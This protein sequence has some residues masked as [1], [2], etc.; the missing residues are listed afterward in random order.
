M[1]F[2]SAA[3]QDETRSAAAAPSNFANLPNYAA[4]VSMYLFFGE[5]CLCDNGRHLK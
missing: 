1:A 5:P 4:N 2:T 3:F